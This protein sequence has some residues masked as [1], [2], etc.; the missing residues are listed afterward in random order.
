MKNKKFIIGILVL[1]IIATGVKVFIL[2]SHAEK[3]SKY[4]NENIDSK[5]NI[6]FEIRHIETDV[7][8]SQTAYKYQFY[9]DESYFVYRYEDFPDAEKI[10][11]EYY[12]KDNKGIVIKD[13]RVVDNDE[14]ESY[15]KSDETPKIEEVFSY[16]L[17]SDNIEKYF[18]TKYKAGGVEFT[19]NE[20]G[21]KNIPAATGLD[22]EEV[23]SYSIMYFRNE[24]I[25]E[26]RAEY[27][28]GDIEVMEFIY[29]SC[30]KKLKVPTLKE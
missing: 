2:P 16:L 25:I 24:G 19:L 23:E 15:L 17:D 10:D 18:D 26:V 8:F 14:C 3:L 29:F 12:C 13:K 5:D 30:S 6:Y 7:E 9:A 20:E 11:E 21:L 4:V 27:Y 28:K 1:V 22:V